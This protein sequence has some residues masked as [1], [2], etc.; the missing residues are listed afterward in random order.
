MKS[1]SLLVGFVLVFLYLISFSVSCFADH[2]LY[3]YSLFF[4]HCIICPLIA[5]FVIFKLC[6]EVTTLIHC[7]SHYCVFSLVSSK[8][9]PVLLIKYAMFEAKIRLDHFNVNYNNAYVF[10]FCY[11]S[12]ITLLSIILWNV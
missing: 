3:F 7:N 8:C 11:R 10:E 1:L 2:C 9:A 12:N 4:R 5:P 6:Y